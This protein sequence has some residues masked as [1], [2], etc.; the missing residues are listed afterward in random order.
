M[1][2]IGPDDLNVAQVQDTVTRAEVM[3]LGES[4]FCND[5]EQEA[6]IAPD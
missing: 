2:R 6:W 4:G 1:H 5:G 3:L